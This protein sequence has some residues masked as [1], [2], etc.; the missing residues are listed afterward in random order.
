M[1]SLEIHNQK[2]QRIEKAFGEWLKIMGY[3]SST[4]Y[5][6]PIY[7][8][9]FFHWLEQQNKDLEKVTPADLALYFFHL[10]TRPCN[11][12][13]GTMSSNNLHKHHQGL[14]RLSYYLR[15]TGQIFLEIDVLLPK[16]QQKART[17]LTRTEIKALYESCL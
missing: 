3:A 12:K 11:N 10:K 4:V 14:K 5:N 2:H 6:L 15:E 13:T 17:I 9:E 16:L 8:R 7:A 1:K